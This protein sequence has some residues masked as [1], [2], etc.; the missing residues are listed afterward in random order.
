MFGVFVV[1]AIFVA[2]L[3]L[4]GFVVFTAERRTKEVAVRKVS[5]ARI[6]LAYP[7]QSC[8][9]SCRR[10]RKPQR[11]LYVCWPGAKLSRTRVLELL[12]C[13]RISRRLFRRSG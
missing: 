5:G 2:C 4:Y 1:I 7:T 8:R 9:E 3:G 12:E 13:G 10:R 6:C 11:A